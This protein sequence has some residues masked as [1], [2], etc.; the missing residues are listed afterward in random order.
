MAAT[1]K[2]LNEALSNFDALPIDL[3]AVEDPEWSEYNAV[4]EAND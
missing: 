4:L 1:G 3:S 2:R